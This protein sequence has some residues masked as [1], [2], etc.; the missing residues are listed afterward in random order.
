[1]LM[2][3]YITPFYLY[4]CGDLYLL[5]S[6]NTEVHCHP[7]CHHDDRSYT[8]TNMDQIHRQTWLKWEISSEL[9]PHVINLLEFPC[10]S[11]ELTDLSQNGT[12]F[13]P[14]TPCWCR[15]AHVYS[16]THRE[17]KSG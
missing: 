13:A 11:L 10:I 3:S 16:A 14:E 1:M 15:R 17:Q 5:P 7:H 8:H 2:G 6:Y 9:S 4:N 12:F